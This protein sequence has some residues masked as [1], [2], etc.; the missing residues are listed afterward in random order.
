MFRSNSLSGS[1]KKKNNATLTR[2]IMSEVRA[3]RPVRPFPYL[4]LAFLAFIWCFFPVQRV[5]I[6][7]WSEQ[8]YCSLQD[9]SH[10]SEVAAPSTC[11]GAFKSSRQ[12]L[13]PGFVSSLWRRVISYM[14]K[15]RTGR[16]W[17]GSRSFERQYRSLPAVVQGQRPFIPLHNFSILFK[18]VCIISKMNKCPS[19][20]Q[21]QTE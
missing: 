4:P 15:H 9:C 2:L 11:S 6:R 13:L 19:A 8:Y 5:K 14:S 21:R 20:L 17:D 7:F 10:C 12:Q 16:W 1:A 3:G 18:F